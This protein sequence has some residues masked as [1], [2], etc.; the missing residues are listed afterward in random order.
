MGPVKIQLRAYLLYALYFGS[1]LFISDPCSISRR[2]KKHWQCW[3]GCAGVK[4]TKIRSWKSHGQPK[5]HAPT[6]SSKQLWYSPSDYGWSKYIQY[7]CFISTKFKLYLFQRH[8]DFDV[9]KGTVLDSELR[10]DQFEEVTNAIMQHVS[11]GALRNL[12][13]TLNKLVS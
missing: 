5:L 3:E 1:I 13:Y 9:T 4:K 8:E 11:Q 12:I 6:I 2:S 7:L 10:P